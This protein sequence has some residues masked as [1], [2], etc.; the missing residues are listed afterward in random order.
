VHIFFYVF[1]LQPVV[2]LSLGHGGEG[3]LGLYEPDMD[4]ADCCPA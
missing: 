1:L 2:S 3:D 4:A